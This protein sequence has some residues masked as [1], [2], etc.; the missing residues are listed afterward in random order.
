MGTTCCKSKDAFCRENGP[1]DF[2]SLSLGTLSPRRASKVTKKAKAGPRA[3]INRGTPRSAAKS[4]STLAP[5]DR[6]STHR[7]HIQNKQPA[8]MISSSNTMRSP[9]TGFHIQE[10]LE[11]KP[12]SSKAGGG[13]DNARSLGRFGRIKTFGKNLAPGEECRQVLTLRRSTNHVGLLNMSASAVTPQ[14]STIRFKVEPA[15]F[16]RENEDF[17]EEKYLVMEFIDKGT[18][19]AV[20]KISEFATGSIRA[21]KTINKEMCQM[22]NNY[23]DEIEIL[24]KLV[25]TLLHFEGDRTTQTW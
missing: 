12:H 2:G 5:T 14:F 23:T 15:A 19:G 7:G 1:D 3:P 8:A 4:K 16:R 9:K 6:P 18:F 21:L 22:T 13:R 10:V 11:F 24:K 17:L 20:R 25:R